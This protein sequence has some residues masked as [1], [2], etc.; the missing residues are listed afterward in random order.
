MILGGF[1]AK[2]V[3]QWQCLFKNFWDTYRCV[4]AT[5]PLFTSSYDLSGCVPFL[6]HGDEGRG[7]LRRPFMVIAW[8][9]L[10]SFHGVDVCNDSTQ[11]S[12]D[13]SFGFVHVY[14]SMHK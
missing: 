8:Q 10:I 14:T 5:H 2:E 4:D 11:L 1:H 12:C 3:Q 6:L 7:L 13:R 9:P